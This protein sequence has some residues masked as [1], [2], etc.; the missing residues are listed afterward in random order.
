MS[1]NSG[2]SNVIVKMSDQSVDSDYN[3]SPTIQSYYNEYPQ[4][5][6]ISTAEALP[7][8]TFYFY[9]EL[10]SGNSGPGWYR[11]TYVICGNEE[12][13]FVEDTSAKQYITLDKE[14]IQIDISKNVQSDKPE[15]CPVTEYTMDIEESQYG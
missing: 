13:S 2:S 10:D 1:Q 3:N 12:L 4:F 14:N 8:N 5:F 15:D 9:L 7:L 6:E 11:I